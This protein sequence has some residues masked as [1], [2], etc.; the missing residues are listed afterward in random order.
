M[1][2]PYIKAP[3]KKS[4]FYL[5]GNVEQGTTLQAKQAG[6]LERWG[7]RRVAIVP[8][9]AKYGAARSHG[10]RAPFLPVGYRIVSSRLAPEGWPSCLF[11]DRLRARWP[12]LD[13]CCVTN[14]T[15]EGIGYLGCEINAFGNLPSLWLPLDPGR[16]GFEAQPA[17]QLKGEQGR[18]TPEI[19]AL[20]DEERQRSGKGRCGDPP[21]F[22][23]ILVAQLAQGDGECL[24]H[25]ARIQGKI[26]RVVDAPKYDLNEKP[27]DGDHGREAPQDLDPAPRKAY[28]LLGLSQSAVHGALRT[29]PGPTGE[30]DLA[31][32]GRKVMPP[33]GVQDP[34]LAPIGKPGQE[35]GGI[36][37]PGTARPAGRRGL[38]G[39]QESRFRDD[40]AR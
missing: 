30:G 31:R 6:S 5:E 12:C 21:G 2:Q 14:R 36:S 15:S 18:E 13:H 11:M 26:P 1:Q 39:A 22:P 16:R 35:D 33:H 29:L 20:V 8:P 10:P 3:A 27:S 9:A 7:R 34:I 23:S 38:E 25:L 17:E 24:G 37:Q 4:A 40:H 19:P 28:L 32:V